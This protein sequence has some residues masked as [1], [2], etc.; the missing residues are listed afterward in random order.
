MSAVS[1]DITP[2]DV[3]ARFRGHVVGTRLPHS[4]RTYLEVI[5]AEGGKWRLVTWRTTYSST[6][7]GENLGKTVVGV[8]I[9]DRTEALMISFSDGSSCSLTAI[10]DESEDALENWEIFTPDGFILAYGPRGRWLWG[11]ASDPDYWVGWAEPLV[12]F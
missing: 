11:R 3:L 6:D 7:A 2:V 1:L 9:D 12:R 4:K 10:P 8:A 5:D